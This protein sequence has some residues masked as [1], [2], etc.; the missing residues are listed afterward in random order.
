MFQGNPLFF[1]ANILASFMYLT[2]HR[3]K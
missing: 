1:L 3:R 2:S